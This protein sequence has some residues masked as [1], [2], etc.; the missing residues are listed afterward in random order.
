M[1]EKP[2]VEV[3]FHGRGG[4]GAWTASLL[5]AQAGLKESKYIQSFPA[6]GPE[7]AGAP[8]TA[9][10]RISREP[11]RIHSSI[12]EPDLIIVLDQTLLGPQ[13]LEGVKDD[14]KLLINTNLKPSEIKDKLQKSLEVWVVNATELALKILGRPITN[15]AML[16]AIVKASEIVSMESIHQVIKERF[17]GRLR[18]QNLELVDIA[19]R[20]VT[21][22]D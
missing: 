22:D 17:T 11:I 18:D 6:F 21:K 13:V 15:T 12:Y 4:Q 2:L 9:F 10:T 5:L 7:R 16:G 14:S 1:K 3:R 20:T 19:Y 8:I